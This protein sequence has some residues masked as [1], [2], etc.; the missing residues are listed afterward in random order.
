MRD[1][2]P[3]TLN[4]HFGWRLKMG[5]WCAGSFRM[6]FQKRPQTVSN[7]DTRILCAGGIDCF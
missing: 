3:G 6:S 7:P 2:K 1:D 5:S 4:L